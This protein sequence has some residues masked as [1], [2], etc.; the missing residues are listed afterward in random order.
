[1]YKK[2]ENTFEI[3]RIEITFLMDLYIFLEASRYKSK[4]FLKRINQDSAR[5]G[6]SFLVDNSFY[7]SL[8]ANFKHNVVKPETTINATSTFVQIK[9]M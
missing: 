3:L 1:M 5:Q 4:L 2:C 8:I 7:A 9:H 6:L